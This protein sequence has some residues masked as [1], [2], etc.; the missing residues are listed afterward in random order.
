MR[1]P[2]PAAGEP[3]S[4]RWSAD[5]S[6]VRLAP[7]TAIRHVGDG[8]TA[9]L[10]II[11][12][13]SQDKFPPA[14]VYTPDSRAYESAWDDTIDVLWT[15]DPEESAFKRGLLLLS[16]GVYGNVLRLMVPLTIEQA[17]LDEGLDILCESIDAVAG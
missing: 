8:A 12:A 6:G 13:F 11:S 10:E 7:P 14:L 1:T 17:V 9:A 3:V 2:L 5:P 4:H 16:C 15:P